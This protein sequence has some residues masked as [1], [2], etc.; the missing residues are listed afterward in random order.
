MTKLKEFISNIYK[1][2]WYDFLCRKEPFT[3]QFTRAMIKHGI[4][5]WIGFYIL[6]GWM[7]FLLFGCVIWQQILGVLGLILLAWLTDHL[8]DE[9]RLN[10]EKY[11]D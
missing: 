7:F 6:C 8:I 1:W 5:F 2:I 9:A 11:D 4:I 3:Y 10:N